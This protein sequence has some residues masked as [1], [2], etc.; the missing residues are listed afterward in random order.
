MQ[1]WNSNIQIL[2]LASKLVKSVNVGQ[3]MSSKIPYEYDIDRTQNP[4]ALSNP[5]HGK[6]QK[7]SHTKKYGPKTFSGSKKVKTQMFCH[8][9]DNNFLHEFL[10]EVSIKFCVF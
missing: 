1:K 4:L 5:L 6:R 2:F 8:F 3:K 10:F 7:K 9:F